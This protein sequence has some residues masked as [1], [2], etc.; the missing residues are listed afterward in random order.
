M[1]LKKLFATVA[2]TVTLFV[3]MP[4]L[5]GGCVAMKEDLA[6]I[7]S[8]I[9]VLE[10]QFIEFQQKSKAQPEEMKA[11]PDAASQ[12]QLKDAVRRLSD[13]E[14]R[15]TV[16]EAQMKELKVS[17]TSLGAAPPEP[18]PVPVMVEPYDGQEKAPAPGR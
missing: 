14:K 3:L 12:R 8:D 2:Y 7:R 10:K 1:T 5:M 15:L 9:T 13:I 6:P 11:Q 17:Q 18:E 16:L 4:L